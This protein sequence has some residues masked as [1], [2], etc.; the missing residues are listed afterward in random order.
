VR[1]AEL[2]KGN[3]SSMLQDVRRGRETEIE[4]INGYLENLGR[5]HRIETPAISM[6]R[7]LVE[8]KYFMPLDLMI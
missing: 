6:L 7:N 4:F 3:I 1:V 2:T 5:E 8:L